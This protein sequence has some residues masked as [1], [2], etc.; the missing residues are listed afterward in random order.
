M[1]SASVAFGSFTPPGWV[2]PKSYLDVLSRFGLNF[3]PEGPTKLASAAGNVISA[4]CGRSHPM[5]ES[6]APEQQDVSRYSHRNTV[7][8]DGA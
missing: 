3:G 2:G 6:T 8:L 7:E 5:A 4:G 1:P